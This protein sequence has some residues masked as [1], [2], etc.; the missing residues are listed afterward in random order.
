MPLSLSAS[1]CEGICVTLCLPPETL[2]DAE[3]KYERNGGVAICQPVT[4]SFRLTLFDKLERGLPI[5]GARSRC[6]RP[7][8]RT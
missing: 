3:I 1:R 2:I 7:G 6:R 5:T 4:P 8:W